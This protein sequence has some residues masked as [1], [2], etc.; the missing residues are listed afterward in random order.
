MAFFQCSQ[1]DFGLKRSR[2]GTNL[3]PEDGRALGGG[4]FWTRSSRTKPKD[5]L[6]V[7]TESGYFNTTGDWHPDYV[8]AN[9]DVHGLDPWV[10]GSS[11]RF[12]A[13]R[14]VP[15]GFKPGQFNELKQ[16]LL[17]IVNNADLPAGE[18]LVQGSRAS[19]TATPT[20]DIDIMLRVDAHEFHAYAQRLHDASGSN[21][22]EQ[23]L[24]A[25]AKGKFGTH[26]LLGLNPSPD[27]L[28]T[29]IYPLQDYA[30]DPV[31]GIQFSVIKSGTAFD[32]GPYISLGSN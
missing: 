12:Y 32:V 29:Q 3:K 2:M 16:D 27:S 14:Q 21:F 19:G 6:N 17:Q 20:S 22:K 31:S 15:Q 23:I 30:E 24:I 18:V 13:M 26:N 25:E 1:A 11:S 8:K 5:I 4:T 9:F 28:G 7:T 10:Q